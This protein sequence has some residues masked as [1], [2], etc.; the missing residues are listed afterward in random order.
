MNETPAFNVQDFLE[1]GISALSYSPAKKTT[2]DVAPSDLPA[3]ETPAFDVQAFLDNG[4]CAAS[5]IPVKKKSTPK[6]AAPSGRHREID[7]LMSLRKKR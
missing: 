6:V 4:I 3:N 2:A 5:N 7:R 1:N